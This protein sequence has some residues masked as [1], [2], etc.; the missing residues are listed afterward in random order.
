MIYVP[1]DSSPLIQGLFSG[2]V[3]GKSYNISVQA[4]SEDI[5]SDSIFAVY[6]TV[7]M[8]PYNITVDQKTIG[9]NSFTVRW[10]SPAGV[11]IFDQYAV[12]LGEQ[13]KNPIII[14][15]D[16]PLV[17]RF[18]EDLH[19][20]RTYQVVVKALSDGDFSWPTTVNVTT[21]PL[22]V[23]DLRL[24]TVKET[25]EKRF[26]W[27]PDPDSRQDGYRVEYTKQDGGDVGSVFV[28]TNF[29]SMDNL[30]LDSMYNITV[31]SVSNNI[32]STEMKLDSVLSI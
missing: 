12:A 11:S 7:P 18:T 5:T 29:F 9:P 4:V 23:L 20:G 21:R 10:S 14:E 19:P 26:V 15:K 30:Q 6:R 25:G 28:D 3:P 1:K 17:A 32:E 24:E 22:P 27:Q 13:R 16:Q 31:K 2:L 8:K